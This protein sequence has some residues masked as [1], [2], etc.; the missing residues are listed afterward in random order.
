MILLHDPC[1]YIEL[2]SNVVSIAALPVVTKVR[3]KCLHSIPS[4]AVI[5]HLCF[6]CMV[7]MS[8]QGCIPAH[9]SESKCS[10]VLVPLSPNPYPTSCPLSAQELELEDT[11]SRL[12]QDLRQRMLTEGSSFCQSSS[13]FECSQFSGYKCFPV[14]SISSP[15]DTKKSASEL[16][17][18]QEILSEI[19]RTVEKRDELVS[20]LEEQRLKEKAEDKDLEGLLLSKGYE[21][22]WAP[23][24]DSYGPEKLEW[25]RSLVW[26]IRGGR[27]AE[28]LSGVTLRC[29]NLQVQTLT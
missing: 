6:S 19:M 14:F 25:G 16:Q 18:E 28:P 11:Q 2:H 15:T 20:V 10:T 4:S 23:A 24:D 7:S 27:V 21:F 8:S 9:H 13:A 17:E 1:F 12:Q 5:C 26:E 3:Y 22:H 29:L